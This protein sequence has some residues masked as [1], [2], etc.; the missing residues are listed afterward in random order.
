[1]RD[2]STKR[3]SDR[4]DWTLFL[5]LLLLS[6]FSIASIYSA[7]MAMPDKQNF[8]FKQG[9]VL[10]GS[11]CIIFVMMLFEP[12]QYEKMTWYLYGFSLFVLLAL[13]LAPDSVAPVI[14]GQQSWFVLPGLGTLQPSEFAK[15]TY[16]MA[17]SLILKR[18]K[19]VHISRS[20][21]TDLW[22]IGKL[23]LCT[24]APLSLIMQQPDFGTSLVF[25]AMLCGY[26]LVSSIPWHWIFLVF[27]S[28]GAIAGGAIY[29]ALS[30]PEWLEAVGVERYALGRL[31][32][33]LSPQEYASGD[34]LQLIR[35]MMA[36]G[37]GQ[38]DGKAYGERDVYIPE[39][40]TD[41]IFSVI[42]EQFGFIGASFLIGIFFLLLYHLTQIAITT[43][44][45]YD[46]YICIGMISMLSFHIFQNIGM[47]MQ[48]LP[49][50][51]IPL[52]FISYGGSS[53]LSNMILI[54]LVFSIR[55]YEK[56][57]MF[58]SDRTDVR[59]M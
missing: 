38:M 51:G 23:S 5:L 13:L 25:I 9:I 2:N 18:H 33:W 10:L 50:T 47:T 20:H 26:I 12:E 21:K 32:S 49:I 42:A 27:G 3:I 17:M 15:I 40:H 6:I 19:D 31:Y 39:S 7:Q 24:M 45:A 34:G 22:L 58:E 1:M 8:A 57:F 29:I 54:G 36:I 52:P 56:E 44:R 55:F 53:L 14:K 16:I 11:T 59:L 46:S 4:I 30:K 41:F 35:S 43:R 48:L 37:S 28:G